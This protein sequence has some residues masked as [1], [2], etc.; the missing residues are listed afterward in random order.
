MFSTRSYPVRRL[1]NGERGAGATPKTARN[2]FGTFRA[3]GWFWKSRAGTAPE[4]T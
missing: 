3:E 1:G 4:L 2:I